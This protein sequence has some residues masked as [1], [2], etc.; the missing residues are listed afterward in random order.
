MRDGTTWTQQAYLK[1]SNTDAF[2]IFGRSVA[3]SG[4]T[5]VVGA[6]L[7]ASNAT[8]INGDQEDNNVPGSGAVYIFTGPTGIPLLNISTRM[9]V[10]VGDNVLIG[11]FIV[12]GTDPKRVLLRAIGPSLADFGVLNALA[13]P[14]IELHKPGDIVV[15]NDN[16]KD[17]QEQE[18]MDT[19]IAANR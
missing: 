8:G 11:G 17:T 2:D 18:I 6:D 1:A 15:T 16:W 5:V 19:G 3:V 9:N 7:E 13:D 14:I 10:G 4:D 12:V